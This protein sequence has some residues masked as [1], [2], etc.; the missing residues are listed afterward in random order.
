MTGDVGVMPGA[1]VDRPE[2]G[3]STTLRSWPAK[4]CTGPVVV[5][6]G[7]DPVRPGAGEAAHVDRAVVLD[8]AAA[9]ADLDPVS[10][11]VD[12]PAGEVVQGGAGEQA[13][14]TRAAQVDGAGVGERAPRERL[15]EAV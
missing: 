12:H 13:D 6:G 2:P 4:T 15:A 1:A 10:A 3:P 8:E 14:V 11:D 9:A 7:A 5:E